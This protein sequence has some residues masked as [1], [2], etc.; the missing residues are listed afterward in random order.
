[1]LIAHVLAISLSV[2]VPFS[3]GQFAYPID[4]NPPTI[5]STFSCYECNGN[6]CD[7]Q[8]VQGTHVENSCTGTRVAC[9]T[10]RNMHTLSYTRTCE[11]PSSI[12]QGV[13]CNRHMEGKEFCFASTVGGQRV[14]IC[15]K[16]CLSDRCNAGALTG[17]ADSTLQTC[18]ACDGMTEGICNMEVPMNSE[19]STYVEQCLLPNSDCW[20]ER[21]VSSTGNVY[22]R[23]CQL[24]TCAQNGQA[25]ECVAN[26]NTGMTTCSQCCLGHLCNRFAKAD[27][28]KTSFTWSTL[29]ISLT[30][31]FMYI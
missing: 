4:P 29:A 7:E 23:G 16:C 3:D 20:T 26:S 9:W 21:R 25:E 17:V 28:A 14:R 31:V 30:A 27:G 6:R 1:M 19:N 15:A 2:F 24:R 18:V 5:S 11:Q 22:V 12:R 13:F 8:Q 10:V